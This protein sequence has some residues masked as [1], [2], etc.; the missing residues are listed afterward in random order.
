MSSRRQAVL[1]WHVS[2]QAGAQVYAREVAGFS[3]NLLRLPSVSDGQRAWRADT[4]FVAAHAKGAAVDP[5][6]R[7]AG[8][9]FVA[10]G[11]GGRGGSSGRI[12]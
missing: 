2:S 3:E 9:K 12:R 8:G 1:F 4:S 5:R 7:R 6:V 11:G 10:G